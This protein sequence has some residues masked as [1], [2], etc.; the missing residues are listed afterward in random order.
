VTRHHSRR[1]PAAF[2]PPSLPPCPPTGHPA[3]R[4][5]ATSPTCYEDT[6][7]PAKCPT[8]TPT[9]PAA[10]APAAPPWPPSDA[11]TGPPSTATHV[12]AN[13]HA[14]PVHRH[15]RRRQ[16]CRQPCHSPSVPTHALRQHR[17]G[18]LPS[19]NNECHVCNLPG[20]LI[21]CDDAR[22]RRTADTAC[23]GLAGRPDGDWLCVANRRR[24]PS[25][26]NLPQRPSRHE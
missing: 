15:S 18:A 24:R 22:C 10:S 23:A 16:P 19:Y 20:L 25:S 9:S 5:A 3:E 2:A 26:T 12:L 1:T 6:S 21:L 17:L 4:P 8:P 11:S 14:K 7:A 13:G